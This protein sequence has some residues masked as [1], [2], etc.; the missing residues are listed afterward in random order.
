MAI[1]CNLWFSLQPYVPILWL[2]DIPRLKTIVPR[3]KSVTR[4][5]LLPALFSKSSVSQDLE[6]TQTTKSSYQQNKNSTQVLTVCIAEIV[7]QMSIEFAKLL[8][9]HCC[10]RSWLRTHSI[11]PQI[12]QSTKKYFRFRS[13]FVIFFRCHV[14]FV[15]T[16]CL[17]K[18]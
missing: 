14:S 3:I 15:Y 13:N 11:N 12:N 4:K 9:Y 6:I 8:R 2:H 10:W 16:F 5:T 18:W 1:T 7:L 17:Q